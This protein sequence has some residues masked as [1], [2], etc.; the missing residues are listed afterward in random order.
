[1]DF[2]FGLGDEEL[3]LMATGRGLGED[4][5]S[6]SGFGVTFARPIVFTTFHEDIVN[7]SPR[8]SMLLCFHPHSG[9][10]LGFVTNLAP[11]ILESCRVARTGPLD[12]V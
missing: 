3:A 10:F 5:S 4:E 1:M 8:P 7:S 6:L 2:S 12:L 9:P 11:K